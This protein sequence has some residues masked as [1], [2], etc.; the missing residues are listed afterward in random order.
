MQFSIYRLVLV[1]FQ[2][3]TLFYF[4]F[5]HYVCVYYLWS[6][7]AYLPISIFPSSHLY[8]HYFH[9][10]SLAMSYWI[11]WIPLLP[12]NILA[13]NLSGSLIWS[14]CFLCLECLFSPYTD[15]HDCA[16]NV[17]FFAKNF[18]CLSEIYFF[19]FIANVISTYI[20]IIILLF[21]NTY[22]FIEPNL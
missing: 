3:K 17:I 9:L 21:Y 5:F 18:F 16:M 15:V 12:I 4:I 2:I 7:F 11:M 19:S 10:T 8:F 14:N 13:D 1:I 22:V 6:G 20:S